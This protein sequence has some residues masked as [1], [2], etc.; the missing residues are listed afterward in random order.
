MINRDIHTPPRMSP[1]E[2]RRI[3]GDYALL[4]YQRKWV[5]DDSPVKI[6]DKGRRI[7][8]S[9][10]EAGEDALYAASEKGASCYYL[11]YNKE[12]SMGFAEDTEFWAKWYNLAS[13]KITG[14]TIMD[15][16][17][18]VHKYSVRFASGNVVECLSGNPRNLRSKGA[19]GERVIIDEFAFMED[20]QAAL[21]AAMAFLVWGGNVRIISTHNGVENPFAELIAQ[22]HEGRFDYSVHRV[23]F[24][25]ALR[26]GLYLRI[27]EVT[28]QEWSEEAEKAWTERIYADY[29]EHAAEELDCVPSRS[30]GRYLPR[31]LV[32][33]AMEKGKDIPVL[34]WRWEPQ[35]TFWDDYRRDREVVDW[36][37]EN[38][39]PILK[40]MDKKLAW[41]VGGDFARYIDLADYTFAQIGQ[42][43]VR[44]HMFHLEL[45]EVPH[46]AQRAILKWTIDQLP[47]F[48]CG[49][50]DAGGN[51]SYLAEAMARLYGPT[52]IH[53]VTLTRQFYAEHFPRYKAAL[54][55]S[56]V[57][58]PRDADILD[59]HGAV[60]LVE[61][62]PLV[63]AA[64]RRTA[65][66]GK[67]RGQRH[68]DAAISCMLNWYASEQ[69]VADIEYVS[70]R[71]PA[72]RQDG[73]DHMSAMVPDAG[74][75]V[76]DSGFGAVGR[77]SRYTHGYKI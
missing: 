51:G 50:F 16:S 10:C 32:E 3:V 58:L 44:R 67:D 30:G 53:Q 43:L 40:D 26:Q 62:I 31:M 56:R 57:V 45:R 9:W 41:V 20:P 24:R 22:C 59:D 70:S 17:N 55:D 73:R 38:V 75:R 13:E 61:G 8:I 27:C 35:W 14:E 25:D 33:D 37:E 65:G 47:R 64:G 5:A 72:T 68:G 6:M 1:D 66:S 63:P 54:Q 52:R 76:L 49:A 69:N 7:G 77:G 39:K 2:L 21:K 18:A 71:M 28:K 12:M 60:K 34:R 23:T 48:R 19:P 29:G 74:H 36:C 15:G 42:D 11:G 46:E 4:P